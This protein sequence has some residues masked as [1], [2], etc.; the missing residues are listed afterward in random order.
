MRLYRG[1]FH[2]LFLRA[3]RAGKRSAARGPSFAVHLSGAV[4]RRCNEKQETPLETLRVNVCDVNPNQD[5]I[6]VL[7]AT[8]SALCWPWAFLS[9]SP[10]KRG[11]LE[12]S[13]NPR[14]CE[15]FLLD[16]V[17]PT[18]GIAIF[19]SL[20]VLTVQNQLTFILEDFVGC[21]DEAH[22]PVFRTFL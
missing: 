4:S 21:F 22:S 8:V 20:Q 17:L 1:E 19:D 9:P 11:H 14:R 10:S 12:E 3:V 18:G 6:L 5:F 2:K 15:S 7:V 16:L 13:S